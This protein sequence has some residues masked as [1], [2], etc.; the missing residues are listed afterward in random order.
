MTRNDD[1]KDAQ[2]ALDPA[3]E[4]LTEFQRTQIQAWLDDEYP[5]DG[6]THPLRNTEVTMVYLL[7]RD[8]VR[9]DAKQKLFFQKGSPGSWFD[10]AELDRIDGKGHYNRQN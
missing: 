7:V 8:L 3:G 5:E 4:N 2:Y 6:P 10:G 1:D 9:Y